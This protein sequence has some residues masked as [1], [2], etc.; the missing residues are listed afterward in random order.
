MYTSFTK[1]ILVKEIS[2]S[3]SIYSSYI[4]EFHRHNSTIILNTVPVELHLMQKFSKSL[5]LVS[6]VVLS[7][8][9]SRGDAPLRKFMHLGCDSDV[10]EVWYSCL[11]RSHR[12]SSSPRKRG[13]ITP[14]KYQLE[15]RRRGSSS[16]LIC[17]YFLG[18]FKVRHSNSDSSRLFF[19]LI[20]CLLLNLQ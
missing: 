19:F 20:L 16:Y 13:V 1:T 10:R 18:R 12:H 3:R 6:V 2:F 14:H 9:D 7:G 15:W 5:G 11:I 17:M 4:F 8:Y